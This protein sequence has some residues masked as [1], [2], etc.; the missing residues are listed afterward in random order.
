[1]AFNIAS[2][3][4]RFIARTRG[5]VREVGKAEGAMK[6]FKAAGRG[7]GRIGGAIAAVLAHQAVEGGRAALAMKDLA[8]QT[9]KSLAELDAL[10]HAAQAV[11]VTQEQFSVTIRRLNRRASDAARGNKQLARTFA[12]LGLDAKKL[13]QLD[14]INFVRAL[15]GALRADSKNVETFARA[16][17]LLDTEGQKFLQLLL[18]A[19]QEFERLVEQGL[20]TGESV[21]QTA[22]GFE[23]ARKAWVLFKRT[24]Q[25]GPLEGL[26]RLF[27]KGKE[28]A[29]AFAK[30]NTEAA[31]AQKQQRAATL[32]AIDAKTKSEL[33][34]DDAEKRKRDRATGRVVDR[35]LE[36][37]GR[38]A[39]G[40]AGAQEIRSKQID[41]TNDRLGQII[42][43]MRNNTTGATV[44]F[45]GG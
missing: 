6:K 30:A 39:R 1:M 20:R 13:V 34:T 45:R 40:S 18:A 38:G 19:P 12:E 15:G 11:G 16:F 42:G 4:V 31:A 24:L 29:E 36:F 14:A 37:L 28:E 9:G 27:G 26:K 2:V 17:Q 44:V 25:T 21:N 22:S 10:N 43:L 41:T 33:L 35:R 7:A 5:F 3:S 8:T 32:A 23:R